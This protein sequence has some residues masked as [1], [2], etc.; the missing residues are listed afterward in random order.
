ME[1]SNRFVRGSWQVELADDKLIE[2]EF[3]NAVLWLALGRL[4]DGEVWVKSV[5]GHHDFR[6]KIQRTPGGFEVI[7]DRRASAAP[8][9]PETE[10]PRFGVRVDQAASEVVVYYRTGEPRPTEMAVGKFGIR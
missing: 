1:E 9:W 6:V 10:A 4:I 5:S 3:Q 7:L 8:W 2:A